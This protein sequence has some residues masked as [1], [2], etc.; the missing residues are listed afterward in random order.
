ML[1]TLLKQGPAGKPDADSAIVMCP[2]S[3]VLNWA[4]EV[5]KWLG[6]KIIPTV[7]TS[8]MK[9]EKIETR[10][11]GF[12]QSKNAGL[13]LASYETL[14]G[15]LE[16]M[17]KR[18]IGVLVCDE[19]HRLKNVETKGWKDLIQIRAKTKIMVTGTP[20]QN[21]LN[22]FYALLAF[23]MPEC[24]GSMAEFRKK[25]ALPIS[26]ARDVGAS[27]KE[28][29]RG[30][31]ADDEFREKVQTVMLR[32][33]NEA[34]AKY[35]PPKYE[36]VVFCSL[37]DAQKRLYTAEVE[38]SALAKEEGKGGGAGAGCSTFKTLT[39]LRKLTSHPQLIA[40][41]T[42]HAA[43]LGQI[44]C[45]APASSRGGGGS[46]GRVKLNPALSGKM[47]TLHALLH[48]VKKTT[49]DRWVLVSNFTQTLDL[50]EELLKQGGMGFQRLDGSVNANKRQ[51]MV[52]SFNAD[53]TQYAFLLSS[54]AGGCGLNLIGA[55]RLI[56]FDPDWN[57]A[58]DAQAMARVWRSGQ[59]KTCYVYR[60]LGTGTIE[61]KTWERQLSK[62]GLAGQV[63]EGDLDKRK[64]SAEELRELFTPDFE[65]RSTCH[66]SLGC[67]CCNSLGT[68]KPGEDEN[69]FT[70]L[71]P[72]TQQLRACDASLASVKEHVSLVF[73]RK[74]DHSGGAF[75]A[76]SS[77]ATH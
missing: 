67:Q 76:S 72:G 61:E 53:P 5:K 45:L 6:D 66:D 20:V 21:D 63:V 68:H 23:C 37:T 57:P 1:W 41:S 58:N 8:D 56:L 64:F 10:L 34:I 38:A 42:E 18:E 50:F 35:L 19:A 39:T 52:D 22:E 59:T 17:K 36:M 2:T 15:N 77:T 51:V 60:F 73:S 43:V 47:A 75:G 9:K 31:V 70:H 14:S 7:V 12:I 69:G 11:R 28:I 29:A 26:K 48:Q 71:L 62:E 27:D 54:K 44:G 16:L 4:A 30:K 25:Y 13:L 40:D 55:N 65:T 3:L 74:T 32:R 33:G 46:G 49:T 24:L